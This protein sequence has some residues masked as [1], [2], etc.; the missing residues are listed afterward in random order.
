MQRGAILAPCDCPPPVPGPPTLPEPRRARGRPCPR[1][2][3]T[4]QPC[5]QPPEKRPRAQANQSKKSASATVSTLILHQMRMETTAAAAAHAQVDLDTPSNRRP[6][7]PRAPMPSPACARKGQNGVSDPLQGREWVLGGREGTPIPANPPRSCRTPVSTSAPGTL[8]KGEPGRV[9]VQTCVQPSCIYSL[10]SVSH[11][12]SSRPAAHPQLQ[13]SQT[14]CSSTSTE[15]R[16]NDA[17]ASCRPRQRHVLRRQPELRLRGGDAP[18]RPVPAP[19]PAGRREEHDEDR[20][21]DDLGAEWSSTK[22]SDF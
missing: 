13:P 11:T 17:G 19:E 3:P 16:P 12:R 9:G 10:W 20:H 14:P 7:A 15:L 22:N 2:P 6:P 5:S 1:A 21:L 4:T 18:A 8:E